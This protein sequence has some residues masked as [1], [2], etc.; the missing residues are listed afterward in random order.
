MKKLAIASLAVVHLASAPAIAGPYLGVDGV[1]Q[2]VNLDAPTLA[3]VPNDLTGLG[4]SA[5]Y[6]L[7]AVSLGGEYSSASANKS[8]SSLS[9]TRYGVDLAYHV[10][11]IEGLDTYAQVDG[12]RSAYSAVGINNFPQPASLLFHGSETDWGAGGGVSIPVWHAV[13]IRAHGGYR[14]TNFADHASGGFV[15]GIGLELAH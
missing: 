11:L 14:S 4:V 6:R 15:F 5:G 2:S 8:G 12:G 1:F 10:N 3:R 13:A 7:G 9:S